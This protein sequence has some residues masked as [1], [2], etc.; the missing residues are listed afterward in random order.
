MTALTRYVRLESGGI[1]R[2]DPEAQRRDVAVT[3]GDTTLILIDT[4]GRPLA[5]WS[6]PAL[7]RLNPGERPALF[8]PDPD[9]S[10]TLEIEDDDMIDAL[11]TVRRTIERRRPHPGRLRIF[12]GLTISTL[13]AALAIF[14]LPEALIRQTLD[15]VPKAK[16][17]EFGATILGHLQDLT[18]PA[19]RAPEGMAALAR[20]TE[21]SLGRG[22]DMR[23]VVLPSAR[24]GPR[25]LPGAI[26]VLDRTVVEDHEDPAAAAGYLVATAAEARVADPMEPLLRH[27]GFRETM[28]LFTTGE[29]S[30]EALAA[31]AEFLAT[32]PDTALPDDILLEAFAEARIPSTPYAYARDVTGETTLGLI[33]ADPMAGQDTGPVLRDSDWVAL[34]N[35][36]EG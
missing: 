14:W 27:A 4:A 20:L 19:C 28:R 21:R 24:P 13:I 7:H 11:E 30:P 5:H 36:C 35:I 29:L 8:S 17:T 23:A 34:Q 33:E 2:P 1:W 32:R 22:S 18:G 12:G 25:H 6:L 31:Y 3:L 10:E 15:A 9:A 16:R 26:L